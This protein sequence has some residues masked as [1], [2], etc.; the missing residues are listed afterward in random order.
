MYYGKRPL[1]GQKL[2]LLGLLHK[3]KKEVTFSNQSC[4][5][6]LEEKTRIIPRNSL[7]TFSE[8]R[9]SRAMELAEVRKS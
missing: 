1:G 3:I 9:P 2:I 5:K 6:A 7:N 4:N 8:P